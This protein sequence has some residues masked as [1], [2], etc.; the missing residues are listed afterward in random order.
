MESKAN[1]QLV[2]RDAS[3]DPRLHSRWYRVCASGW[4]ALGVV[5]LMESARRS[6]DQLGISARSE[7]NTSG[8]CLYS[9]FAKV[10]NQLELTKLGPVVV[11][12]PQAS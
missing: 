2:G 11:P 4:A 8:S 10:P 1:V 5:R 7:A 12:E 3:G 6:E 9:L